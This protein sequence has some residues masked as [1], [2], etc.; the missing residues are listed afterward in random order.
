MITVNE[1]LIDKITEAIHLLRTGKVPQPIP[2]PD[3][4]PDNEV[5]QLITFVNRFLVEF[6]TFAAAMEQIA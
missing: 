6:A 3:D 1:E 4:L 2:I 5:R